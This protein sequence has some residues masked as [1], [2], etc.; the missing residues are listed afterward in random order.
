[1]VVE[2]A[3][4][5]SAGRAEARSIELH[6]KEHARS[7]SLNKPE[8][9]AAHHEA[10]G[11][12]NRTR[13]TAVSELINSIDDAHRGA[14]KG[15]EAAPF[16]RGE[17]TIV[18]QTLDLIHRHLDNEELT[19]QYVADRLHMNS[20]YLSRRF[21]RETGR[22]FS[23]YLQAAR[24]D[25]ARQLLLEGATVSMTAHDCG[26]KDASYFIRVFR[27]HWGVTPGELRK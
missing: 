24:M 5:E 8:G 18:K 14:G 15:E 1:M 17:N 21:K 20:S 2:L 9:H 3:V 10:E 12:P 6:M 11:I 13:T 26:F 7:G 23:D 25:R 19:L 4:S 22:A 16:S 27:K